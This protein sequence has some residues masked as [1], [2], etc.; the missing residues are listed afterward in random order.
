MSTL[1]R[2]CS[3]LPH[4]CIRYTSQRR[5]D[6][7]LLYS[8]KNIVLFPFQNI[9]KSKNFCSSSDKFTAFSEKGAGKYRL[10]L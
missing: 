9:A 1:Y 4:F 2:K 6:I 5:Q 7:L 10:P 3:A 8:L